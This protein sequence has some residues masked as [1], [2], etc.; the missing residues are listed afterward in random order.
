MKGEHTISDAEQSIGDL[1]DLQNLRDEVEEE[2]QMQPYVMNLRHPRDGEMKWELEDPA[3]HQ[4]YFLNAAIEELAEDLGVNID[5]NELIPD[6]GRPRKYFYTWITENGNLLYDTSVN[7]DGADAFYESE[8]AAE[9]ALERLIDTY[10][11]EEDRYRKSNLHKVKKMD[12]VMEGVEVFTEQ[13]G[14]DSFAPD[15]GYQMPE[16]Y[17][18]GLSELAE[19]AEQIEW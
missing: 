18:Q 19:S 12:K 1:F 14:L 4:V 7:G 9:E 8:E 11:E 6:G 10:P 2:A 5:D 13:S 17:S 15:G 16:G 3:P